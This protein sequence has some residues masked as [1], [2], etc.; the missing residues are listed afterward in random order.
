[1]PERSIFVFDATYPS[2]DVALPI[3]EKVPHIFVSD[4]D[5]E[6]PPGHSTLRLQTATS[7]ISWQNNLRVLKDAA[8]R[9]R[10]SKCVV[11]A[12]SVVRSEQLLSS[13]VYAVYVCRRTVLF[14]GQKFTSLWGSR[15]VLLRLIIRVLGKRVAGRWRAKIAKLIFNWRVSSGAM[16]DSAEKSLFGVYTEAD[17]FSLPLDPVVRQPDRSSIYGGYTRGWYL[18]ELSNRKQRYAVQTTRHVLHQVSLH[19]ADVDGSPE[20]FL[21]QNKRPLDYPYFLNNSRPNP[22]YQVSCC[23]EVKSIDRGI[24]LLHYTPSY[25]H[26]LIDGVPRILDLIDDGINFDRYPLIMQPLEPFQRQMLELLGIY[27]HRHVVT[28]GT[29]DWCH[30]RECIMPTAYFPFAAVDLE[31]PSGQ[32]DRA[33]LLR[34]RE[35]LLQRMT[36]RADSPSW[37]SV[38]L[39]VS[40]AE[41]T[42]RKLTPSSESAV[43]SL[44]EARGFQTVILERLPWIEQAALMSRAE[45]IVGLHGAGLAN[46]VF[47]QAKTLVEF[48]N[49][50]AA[51][52]YFAVMARELGMNY[53]YIVGRLEGSSQNFDNIAIDTREVTILLNHLG[54][55]AQ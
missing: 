19:V 44:L 33:L 4:R 40:R 55:T 45:I 16:T 28:V 15:W 51:R 48:Q 27:P 3:E 53:A 50:L 41:A 20:R 1:M 47:S 24:D 39:Y 43:R 23:R 22:S 46:A 52:S 34:I 6:P 26:W 30:V 10:C 49:P 38:R 17:T 9:A 2:A 35:R 11:V 54:M 7:P 32:P 18:P 37:S 42:R 21:F 25:Y 12:A 8:R 36:H 31:N 5:I 14:D 13:I 29:G